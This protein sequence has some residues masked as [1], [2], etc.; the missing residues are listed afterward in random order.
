MKAEIISFQQFLNEILSKDFE[1]SE[2][3]Y[4][5][6]NDEDTEWTDDLND[7]TLNDIIQNKNSFVIVKLQNDEE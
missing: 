4:W 5:L 1:N 6:Y 3:I 2:S 7:I